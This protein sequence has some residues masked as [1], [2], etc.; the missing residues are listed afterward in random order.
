MSFLNINNT[1]KAVIILRENAIASGKSLMRLWGLTL[2]ERSLYTLQKA[3]IND[4]IIVC[5]SYYDAV[6]E[7]TENKNLKREFKLELFDSIGDI[8]MSNDKFLVVNSNVIFDERIIKNLITRANNNSII[9]VDSSPKYAEM[10]TD[11]SERFVNVGIFLCNKRDMHILENITQN[12]FIS[13][14]VIK[15]SEM[16]I[17]DVNGSFWYKVVAQENLKTAKAILL[18][19]HL[20]NP[21][22]VEDNLSITGRRIL[23]K[24]LLKWLVS[25]RLSPNQISIIGLSSFLASAFLFSFGGYVYNIIGGIFML[26]GMSLDFSDGMVARL[27]FRTSKYGEWL[28]HIFDKIAINFIIFGATIGLY[29]QTGHILSWIVGIFLLISISLSSFMNK[30][31]KEV[32]NRD[33]TSLIEELDNSRREIALKRFYNFCGFFAG[34]FLWILIGAFLNI[35][36]ISFLVI[37]IGVNLQMLILFIGKNYWETEK[38]SK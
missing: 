26:I 28:E 6:N 2:L 17:Y 19:K 21:D 18:N 16:E 3:G 25:T 30:T 34:A 31:H 33:L 11:L 24:F 22:W 32:F 5:G 9:C 15:N 12:T 37:I 27:T 23:S 4:F 36:L 10:D 7:Y 20:S 1:M 13:K 29:I 38:V 8:Q 35:L 14:E